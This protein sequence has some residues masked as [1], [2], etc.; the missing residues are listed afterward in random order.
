MIAAQ[1]SLK[2]VKTLL[3][4]G[5]GPGTYAMAFLARNPGLRATVCDRPAALEV[6]KEI[7]AT[8]KAGAR[9]SYLPLD[10][11]KDEYRLLKANLRGRAAIILPILICVSI[12]VFL[13]AGRINWH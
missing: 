2:G 5:G 3:D 4:F 12:S 8:Q 10:L 13:Q 11:L 7:A 1:L 6:A 9:L